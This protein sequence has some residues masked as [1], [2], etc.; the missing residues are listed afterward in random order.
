M[1]GN[2]SIF[3]PQLL[4]RKARYYIYICI[5]RYYISRSILMEIVTK[6]GT[7]WTEKEK[8]YINLQNEIHFI[9]TSFCLEGEKK[10]WNEKV[11][12]I[13]LKGFLGRRKQFPPI[14]Q[15]LNS[16]LY[17]IFCFAKFYFK[18]IQQTSPWM[19]L[20]W[21]EIWVYGYLSCFKTS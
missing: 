2:L 7:R 4:R 17:K 12:V 11:L 14:C 16:R 8:K 15:A 10:W 20:W 3:P 19:E 21:F 9:H 5:S 6:I 1:F 18:P 13:F